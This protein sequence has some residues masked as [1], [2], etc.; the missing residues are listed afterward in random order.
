MKTP[1]YRQALSHGWHLAW[2]H[3]WLW[4][5]GLFAAFLGPIGLLDL[6]MQMWRAKNGDAVRLFSF[7]YREGS[8]GI[9]FPTETWGWVGFLIVVVLGLFAF[10]VMASVV[11]QGAL[12][13][14]AARAAKSKRL[15]DVKTSWHVGLTHGWRIFF[16][17]VVRKILL[18][19][20]GGTVV[21][22]AS[23]YA[24]RGGALAFLDFSLL[25]I[26]MIALGI[27]ISFLSLYAI[28]YIVVEEYRFQE[29][30]GAAWRLF[31][32]HWMVSI[33]VGVIL[34]FIHTLVGL[35]AVSALSIFIF[36][37]IGGYTF[38]IVFGT[39]ALVTASILISGF[40]YILFIFFVGSLLTIF[41]ISTW[42]HL[43]MKMHRHGIGSRVVHFLKMKFA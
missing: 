23:L 41:T 21:W 13:H 10:L 33:E 2:K 7:L 25:A 12:V 27:I 42:T 39:S 15:P 24:D 16:I 19:L 36:P 20:I 37:I 8:A 14:I 5:L 29:A 22:Q 30:I 34:F 31:A 26:G 32:D 17:H 18:T 1:L 6:L 40:L 35:A 43:F 28:A 11:S 9:S 4:P 3:I 38:S